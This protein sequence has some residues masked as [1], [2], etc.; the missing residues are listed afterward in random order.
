M[1]VYS[2]DSTTKNTIDITKR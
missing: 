2:C 1:S